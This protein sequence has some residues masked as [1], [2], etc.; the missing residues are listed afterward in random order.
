M[1]SLNHW[2][3]GLLFRNTARQIHSEALI[4]DVNPAD[5][6]L[7]GWGWGAATDRVRWRQA[8]GCGAACSDGLQG[9]A[10]DCA[11]DAAGATLRIS[12]SSALSGGSTAF[13]STLVQKTCALA[14]SPKTGKKRCKVDLR[15]KKQKTFS[16]GEHSAS[17]SGSSAAPSFKGLCF[18]FFQSKNM[19]PLL[20]FWAALGS[21]SHG[22]DSIETGGTRWS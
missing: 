2:A 20:D 9:E 21:Q 11:L 16:N 1:P 5:V 10:G 19:S 7:W 14:H 18:S 8:I 15:A 3:S 22:F 17:E 12:L 4:T 6:K 13:C